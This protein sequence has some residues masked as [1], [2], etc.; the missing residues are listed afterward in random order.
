MCVIDSKVCGLKFEDILYPLSFHSPNSILGLT[1][2]LPDYKLTKKKKRYFE[3]D[4]G[5]LP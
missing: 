2:L 4:M 3:W 5:Q 1:G